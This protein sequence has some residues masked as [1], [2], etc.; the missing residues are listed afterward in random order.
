MGESSGRGEAESE[1]WAWHWAGPFLPPPPVPNLAALSGRSSLSP[2]T[3]SILPVF[4]PISS[5][6]EGDGER[7]E[8]HPSCPK[9]DPQP[10]TEGTLGV[11]GYSGGAASAESCEGWTLLVHFGEGRNR[12]PPYQA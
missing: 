6:D 3:Y 2:S 12:L 1:G 4:H 11:G 8:Q 10:F 9:A 7:P 5:S